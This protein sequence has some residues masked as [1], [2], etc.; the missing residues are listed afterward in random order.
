M[1]K[2]G[3]YLKSSTPCPEVQGTA[4]IYVHEQSGA[5]LLYIENNDPEKVFSIAFKTIPEDSTGVFH[6]LEHSVLCGSQKYP[7]R[8]PFVDLLKGSMQTFL[9]AMTFPDKTMYPIATL[10]EKDYMNL[11]RAYALYQNLLPKSSSRLM[12][13]FFYT[14]IK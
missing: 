10:N 9:N 7:L 8:E 6:I 14:Q 12:T 3:F 5:Q 11:I 13:A 4:H 1:Q 2:H